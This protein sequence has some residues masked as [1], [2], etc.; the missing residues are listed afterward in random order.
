MEIREVALTMPK[1]EYESS[2]GLKEA[3]KMLGMGVALLP[4]LTFPA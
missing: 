2:F 3:L 4:M 1:F